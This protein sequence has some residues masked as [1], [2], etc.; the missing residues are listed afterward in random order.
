MDT[1]TVFRARRIIFLPRKPHIWLACDPPQK[2]LKI[3]YACVPDQNDPAPVKFMVGHQYSFPMENNA[4]HYPRIQINNTQ[5]NMVF[6]I[7]CLITLKKSG[8]SR[9]I[10]N[11]VE[12][13]QYYVQ[14]SVTKRYLKQFLNAHETNIYII[15]GKLKPSP[16][17]IYP[18]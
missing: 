18:F 16:C 12:S 9:S 2:S 13:S 6:S 8:L 4:W 3:S 11:I 14:H 10:F 5:S 17:P 1:Y 15:E 7:S